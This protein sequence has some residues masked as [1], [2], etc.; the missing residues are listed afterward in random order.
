MKNTILLFVALFAMLSPFV[1]STT[2]C[3]LSCLPAIKAPRLTAGKTIVALTSPAGPYVNSGFSR[4]T[5]LNQARANMNSIGAQ[6]YESPHMND[7][8]VGYLAG[9]DENRAAD[10]NNA[11]TNSSIN[12]IVANR[13]GYGC[14]RILDL[15][16]YDSIALNPKII[17]G[18]SDVTALI[19]AIYV[20]TGLIT[21]YGPMN[22]DSWTNVQNTALG[23][24]YNSFFSQ[25]VLFNP[26][27]VL[28]KNPPEF[29]GA[30]VRTIVPGKASGKLIGGNLSLFVTIVGTEYMP[31]AYWQGAILFLEDTGEAPYQIDRMFAEL[32]TRGVLDQIA[33]FVWGVCSSCSFSAASSQSPEDAVASFMV[34]RSYPSYLGAMIGH[35]LTSQF[36][37]PIGGEVEIDATQGTIRMLTAAVQ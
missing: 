2:Q 14:N 15:I 32:E 5:F 17:Q 30:T 8:S 25:Q 6:I 4:T 21:F 9:T 35:E 27:L 18:Y 23:V 11:F 20:K 37:L 10:I 16:D 31:D 34:G 13:G 12:F 36:T 1:E 7:V 22:V 3:S 26:N 29:T 24:S 19:N 28:F 33:G